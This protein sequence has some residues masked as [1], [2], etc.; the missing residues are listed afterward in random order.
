MG[1]L[2]K[3]FRRDNFRAYYSADGFVTKNKNLGFMHSFGFD[4]AYS[5]SALYEHNGQKSPWTR[6]DIRWRAH[7]CVWAARHGLNLEGDFVECG[8]DTAILSGTIWKML[9]FAKQERQFFLFDTFA[10]VPE[11]EGMSSSEKWLRNYH[12]K[13]KYSDTYEFII[14][15]TKEFSNVKIVRGLLPETLQAISGR[16]I[17]YLSVDLNN[18]PSE[19]A[20]IERLWDQLVPGAIVVLDDYAFGGCDPQHHMWNT[21][22]QSKGLMV[23]SLPTGQGLL[24]KPPHKIEQD[25]SKTKM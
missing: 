24:I 12:N 7:I 13:H 15:K 22:A 3:L 23:A 9:D 20:V 25:M 5:W 10:G 21:F 4:E 16:K 17:A 6:V 1:I 14:D 8:V 19:K 18:A 11:V 2:K